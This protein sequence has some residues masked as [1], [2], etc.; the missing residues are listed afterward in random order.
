[1]NLGLLLV[2]GTEDSVTVSPDQN[3]SYNFCFSSSSTTHEH[4]WPG[5]TTEWSKTKLLR[6]EK[7]N[8]QFVIQSRSA[9][10]GQGEK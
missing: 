4:M 7:P 1:M 3:K 9:E 5:G 10:E 6:G 8:P 2:M